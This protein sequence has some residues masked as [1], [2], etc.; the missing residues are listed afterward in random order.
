M[1][2]STKRKN[3]LKNVR[4]ADRRFVGLALAGD[5]SGALSLEDEALAGGRDAPAGASSRMEAILRRYASLSGDG[6]SLFCRCAMGAGIVLTSI[7]LLVNTLLTP[8]HW[9]IGRVAITRNVVDLVVHIRLDN[10][11]IGHM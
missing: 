11:L 3:H 10:L 5:L 7:S 6:S 1:T 9:Q 8:D 4:M 2:T